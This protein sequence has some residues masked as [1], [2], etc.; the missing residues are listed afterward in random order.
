MPC[1]TVVETFSQMNLHCLSP[2][3]RT[4]DTHDLLS[5]MYCG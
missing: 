5:E 4:D 1:V 3:F 2:I